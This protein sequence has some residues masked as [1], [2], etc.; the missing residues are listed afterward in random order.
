MSKAGSQLTY[1]GGDATDAFVRALDAVAPGVQSANTF[2][3]VEFLIAT[4]IDASDLIAVL[5]RHDMELR[6]NEG[7]AIACPRGAADV[8]AV[9]FQGGSKTTL[10][11]GPV[12]RVR[13]MNTTTNLSHLKAV[14]VQSQTLRVS[15]TPVDGRTAVDVYSVIPTNLRDGLA[16]RKA[17]GAVVKHSWTKSSQ[18]FIR[19]KQAQRRQMSFW[20]SWFSGLSTPHQK[21]A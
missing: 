8:P 4:S 19:R 11:S 6:V 21:T 9:A 5:M 12:C 10:L 16:H 20:S 18:R 3:G 15:L 1:A 13:R 17:N 7:V 14:L 2:E